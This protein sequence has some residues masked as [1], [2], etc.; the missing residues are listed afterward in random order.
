MDAAGPR[1][2]L[3]GDAVLATFAGAEDAARRVVENRLHDYD[4]DASLR[5]FNS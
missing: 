4:S 5:R 1:A 3:A 2:I